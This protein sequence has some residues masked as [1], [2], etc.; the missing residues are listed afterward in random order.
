ML[1]VHVRI[2]DSAAGKPT[3]VRVRFEAPDQSA[4]APFGRLPHFATEP[5]QDVGGHL[6]LGSERFFFIDGTCEIRL[7]AG[8]VRI[9]A[10][11][12][13]EYAPLRREVT[14][15]PG[16]I[17][18]RL[19][20]ERWIDL[21]AQ[22]WYSGDTRATELAPHA[23]LLEGSAED[24][25]VVNLLALD[26][27]PQG[28]RPPA[29]PNLLAF[30]GTQPSLQLPGCVVAVNTLNH[31][32]VLG[33]MALLNCHRPVYPLRFGAPDDR[34]D[35]SVMD[36]CEQCHRKRGLVVWPDLPRLTSEQPQGEALAALILGQVDAFEVSR[37]ADP[38]PEVLGLWYQLLD[39]GLRLPLVGGSGKNSNALPLGRVRTYAR[40]QPDEELSY[41]AWIEAVRAGRTFVTNGPLLFLTVDEQIPGAVLSA[42]S[43]GR[44]VRVRMEAHSVVPFEQLELL[45]NSRVQASKTASGNRLSAV[46]ETE[47]P[48]KESAWLA[49]RCWSSEQLLG[50]DGQ[51]V[52]AQTSPVYVAVEGKPLRLCA[53]TRAPLDQV[54][55]RTQEWVRNKS[56]CE[57]EQQR[58]QLAG[59]LQTAR[60]KLQ[61]RMG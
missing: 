21:R 53:E 55:E 15:G 25:A 3:P 22:G 29:L 13:P 35:W 36:W 59:V 34:D 51:C 2:N 43:E 47:V 1:T 44:T 38:E 10:E 48:L 27:P 32:P 49:A 39:C 7:P 19:A 52:Y 33:T 23:A 11:K 40:L 46:M 28:D 42:P 37:F 16:Q 61:R 4:P 56:R 45:V 9:L 50:G 14:L 6:L 41:G 24:L 57:T 12:G 20:I 30:S 5:G 8:V 54:L 60:Q 31:H 17:S 26:R 18:L 58:D